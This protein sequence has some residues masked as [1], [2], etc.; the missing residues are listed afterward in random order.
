MDAVSTFRPFPDI[1]RDFAKTQPGRIAL[2]FEG[3]ETTY[4]DFEKHTNQVAN[5]L[6]AAGVEPGDRVAFIGKNSDTYFEVFF[7]AAKMGGVTSPINWRLAGPE[8]A[9]IL[10]DSRAPILFVGPE[11]TDILKKIAGE[12]PDLKTTIATEAKAGNWPAFTEWRDANPDTSPEHRLGPRSDALQLYTSGTTG[13]AKGVMLTAGNLV[14]LQEVMDRTGAPWAN[15]SSDDV[16]LV[17][18]PVGHIAGTGW[19]FWTLVR[20]AKAIIVRDFDPGHILDLI[21]REKINKL[22]LV[23]SALQAVVNHPRARAVDY[24]HLDYISYGASP[25]PLAL[26][27]EC[28]QVFG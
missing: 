5:A 26:L 14:S 23:P 1:T 13:R 10:R 8:V 11:F 20:G 12:C 16:S 2:S 6:L 24:A 19:G 15:W 18:M 28:V 9:Y 25:I 27:R 22:F 4:A 3:R 21:E 17:A 7:G